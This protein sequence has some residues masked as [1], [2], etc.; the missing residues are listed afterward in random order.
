MSSLKEHSSLRKRASW[1]SAFSL[2]KS[3]HCRTTLGK[4]S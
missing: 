2:R 4:T 3:S 1:K